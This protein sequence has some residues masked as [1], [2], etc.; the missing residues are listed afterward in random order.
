[1][2]LVYLNHSQVGRGGVDRAFSSDA[3]GLWFE[4]HSIS[5]NTTSLPQS[6]IGSL[7]SRAHTRISEL[8]ER[9]GVKQTKNLRWFEL[10]AP[11]PLIVLADTLLITPW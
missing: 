10:F 3:L 2:V 8:S 6:P 9:G 11:L 1:M 7:R 4:P 5:K